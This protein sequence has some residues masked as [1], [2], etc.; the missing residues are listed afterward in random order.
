MSW[1]DSVAFGQ[2]TSTR[3]VVGCRQ[4]SVAALYRIGWTGG[5][6]SQVPAFQARQADLVAVLMRDNPEAVML[7]LVNPAVAD[8]DLQGRT[9]WQGRA[10][11]AGCRLS[12]AR[13]RG[14]NANSARRRKSATVADSNSS[15]SAVTAQLGKG[16][17]DLVLDRHEVGRRQ[18]R[19][20]RPTRLGIARQPARPWPRSGT[21]SGKVGATERGCPKGLLSKAVCDATAA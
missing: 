1:P 6:I 16:V 4:A 5:E 17:A 7:Q 2:P 3:V 18:V 15:R 19:Q 13:G 9:G 20:P 10:K 12:R 11:P 14:S 21:P 8:R